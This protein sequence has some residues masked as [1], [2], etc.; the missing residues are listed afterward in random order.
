MGKRAKDQA[1]IG[2]DIV[3]NAATMRRGRTRRT[4]EMI[5]VHTDIATIDGILSLCRSY[6]TT[7]RNLVRAIKC[8]DDSLGSVREWCG[9]DKRTDIWISIDGVRLS[10]IGISWIKSTLT[11]TRAAQD[12]IEILTSGDR[13]V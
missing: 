9:S 8:I 1:R 6:K 4:L 10:D 7:P 2:R 3:Y 13:K 12:V 11:Q 5:T